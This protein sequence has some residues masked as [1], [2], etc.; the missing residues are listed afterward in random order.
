MAN[1]EELQRALRQGSDAK[2]RLSGLDEQ[3][4]QA[5]DRGVATTKKDRYGQV[6]PLSVLADVVGQSRSRR[7]MRELAPQREAARQAIAQH[8]NAQ[9]LYNARIAAN[10]VKQDQ[11]NWT[12]DYAFK[13]AQ[14]A[15]VVKQNQKKNEQFNTT[16]ANKKEAAFKLATAKLKE[17]EEAAALAVSEQNRKSFI[18]QQQQIAKDKAKGAPES[19]MNPDGTGV[20]SGY[21]TS[22][23]GFVDG[24]DKPIDIGSMVSHEFFSDAT[25][26]AMG[27]D[28][29]N[30]VDLPAEIEGL[31]YIKN[32][33]TDS[34]LKAGTGSW[35]DLVKLY[36]NVTNQMPEAQVATNRMNNMTLDAITPMLQSKLFGMLSDSD[37]AALEDTA[38]NAETEP[39]VAIKWV[40][41][42]LKPRLLRAVR[43]DP[44]FAKHADAIA[45][46]FDEV[47]RV[48]MIAQYPEKAAERY[49]EGALTQP[50]VIGTDGANQAEDGTPTTTPRNAA[51]APDINAVNAIEDDIEFIRAYEAHMKGL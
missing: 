38:P 12:D 25:N 8:E 41:D 3:Y 28:S 14:Q 1:I 37:R 23:A 44:E 39:L 49:G 20:V 42:K 13:L 6:S 32:T 50:K 40:E 46:K 5:Q 51:N 22:G 4:Q 26:T 16:A 27:G 11:D 30:D 34:N 7:D 43:K 2:A 47:V 21:H 33:L 15:E 9:G 29:E 19:W 36:A 31:E 48:S 10:K 18:A 24:K 17:E 35:A 45:A